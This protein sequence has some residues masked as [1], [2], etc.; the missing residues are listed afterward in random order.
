MEDL[1]F[2]VES[3][4]IDDETIVGSGDYNGSGFVGGLFA[5]FQHEFEAGPLVYF[6]TG[7]RL[8]NLG[9][10]EG[11]FVDDLDEDIKPNGVFTNLEEDPV[12]DINFSGFYVR[13]GFGFA[14]DI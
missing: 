13:A 8:R 10:F 4:V 14:L 12:G 7:Y 2:K 6:E 5:G 11:T 3:T 1:D 9:E